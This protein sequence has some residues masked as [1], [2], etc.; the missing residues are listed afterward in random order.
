MQVY[1]LSNSSVSSVITNT[2]NNTE[3]ESQAWKDRRNVWKEAHDAWLITK[4]IILNDY[5]CSTV[6]YD[7]ELIAWKKQDD[8]NE[9]FDNLLEE[10]SSLEAKKAFIKCCQDGELENAIKFLQ[11]TFFSKFNGD[12]GRARKDYNDLYT[13]GEFEKAKLLL[14]NI[15]LDSTYNRALIA[16]VMGEQVE[17]V[18]WLTNNYFRTDPTNWSLTHHTRICIAM[19]LK[20]ACKAGNYQIVEYLLNDN[21]L[22]IACSKHSSFVI[23]CLNEH[24]NIAKIIDRC[25][26]SLG[27]GSAF[28]IACKEGRIHIA[29]WIYTLD[30]NQNSNKI[31]PHYFT[32]GF[33]KS[34]ENGHIDI[35]R[36][37]Y[38]IL[39]KA[40]DSSSISLCSNNSLKRTIESIINKDTTNLE[41]DASKY[42]SIVNYLKKRLISDF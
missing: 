15:N 23:A 16:A 25:G 13:N 31:I 34:C 18:K 37:L 36:W 2:N 14:Q 27:D 42:Q 21:R 20:F 40:A 33:I 12:G 38:P 5:N 9:A 11:L 19:A 30:Y 10:E 29:K 26:I 7:N 3:T 4:Q 32:H 22:N 6:D 1:E 28:K 17:I 8:A 24:F 41:V 39:K 35:V